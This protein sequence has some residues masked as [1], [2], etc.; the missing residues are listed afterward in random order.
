MSM[1]LPT[2]FLL[3]GVVMVG[4]FLYMRRVRAAAPATAAATLALRKRAS[5]SGRTQPS[6]LYA[7]GQTMAEL[8]A[9]SVNT[10]F[11][12]WGPVPQ[13]AAVS[14]GT[15]EARAAARAAEHPGYY[16]WSGPTASLINPEISAY[17]ASDPYWAGDLQDGVI[18]GPVYD[19]GRD[20][21][22]YSWAGDSWA[23]DFN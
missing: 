9:R 15:A 10:A 11:G 4:A 1:K 23:G 22:E 5:A 14:I 20:L 18:G 21:S 6:Q 19:V 3:A 2:P 8:L 17:G 16:G 13:S 12:I 7:N